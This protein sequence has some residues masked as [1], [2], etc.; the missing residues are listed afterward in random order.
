MKRILG[1]A[2]VAAV[3]IAAIVWL[4]NRGD[5]ETSS[6]RFVAV[7]RGSL[8]QVVAATGTLTPVTTVE[9]GTQASGQI[10]ELYVDFND[11]VSKGQLLARIDPT[12][13]RQAVRESEASLERA[14]ADVGQKEREFDRTKE[15]HDRQGATDSEYDAAEYALKIARSNLTSAEVSLERALNNLAYTEIYSPIDGIVIQRNVDVGQTVAASLSA[16][17][18]FLIAAD[19]TEMEI[20]ASVD[21]SDIGTIEVGQQA[22]FTVQA[23]PDRTFDGAVRQVRLQSS[24]QENVVNYTVVVGVQNPDGELLPGMTAT[25]EFVTAGAEDILKVPNAAL[26]FQPPE[27]MLV[28]FRE[29]MMAQMQERRAA[30]DSAGGAPAGPAG[31]RPPGGRNMAGMEPGGA[32]GHGG[33]TGASRSDGNRLWML[34]ENGELTMVRVRPGITD[35]QY[36]QIS[37]PR[38]EE[39]MQAIAGIVSGAAASST[40]NPFQPSSGQPPRRGPPGGF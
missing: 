14:R 20:L 3:V 35:G 37:G 38:I 33:A 21:E 16:P 23:F 40:S 19:L 39:G 36:T 4:T 10:A 31:E 29:R 25:V 15:L 8:E 30:M 2:G 18:L 24:T 12:L 34:D 5:A 13:Q 6:W 22:R 17:L 11:Q 1:L 26:R 7:E 9:V 32:A 28:A 27:E